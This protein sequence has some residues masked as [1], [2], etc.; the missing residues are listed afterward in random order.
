MTIDRCDN[1][2]DY[3]PSN[4]RWAT[5]KE[6]QRNRRANV[7]LTVGGVSR[8]VSEWAEVLGVSRSTLQNRI[9]LG[10]PHEKIINTKKGE[11]RNAVI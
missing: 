3:E 1:N 10:W 6:Q 8:C 2:G 5:R 9:R 11:P 7:I 4:C